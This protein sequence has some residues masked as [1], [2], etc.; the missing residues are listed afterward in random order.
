MI[1]AW[2]V[3]IVLMLFILYQKGRI[4]NLE[5]QARLNPAPEQKALQVAEPNAAPLALP[6]APEHRVIDN[7]DKPGYYS[8][9][10]FKH[11]TNACDPG[12]AVMIN[13]AWRRN[14]V[15]ANKRTLLLQ[16]LKLECAERQALDQLHS[17]LRGIQ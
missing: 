10:H 2:P 7:P 1:S 5:R 3:I 9:S 15:P 13:S 17:Q 4:V 6:L 8:A 12:F 11:I 14:G 16:A